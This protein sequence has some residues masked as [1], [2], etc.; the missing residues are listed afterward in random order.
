MVFAQFLAS[1]FAAPRVVAVWRPGI[2]FQILAIRFEGSELKPGTGK[3]M[4]I[5]SANLVF[6]LCFLSEKSLIPKG[7]ISWIDFQTKVAIREAV[8]SFK[9]RSPA[10]DRMISDRTLSDSFIFVMDRAAHFIDLLIS[11]VMVKQSNRAKY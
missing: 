11:S 10:F 4:F 7:F 8:A 5:D 1:V 3:S 6:L 9:Q 2:I